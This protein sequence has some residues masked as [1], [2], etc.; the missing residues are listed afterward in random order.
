MVEVS[1]R[2]TVEEVE[3]RPDVGTVRIG[4]RPP[5]RVPRLG[6]GDRRRQ[7]KRHDE[8]EASECAA[9]AALCD[10]CD[11]A[12]HSY[13]MGR[14]RTATRT[15]LGPMETQANWDEQWRSEPF[16]FEAPAKEARTPRWLA[17]ERLVHDRFGSFG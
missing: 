9:P 17:Q 1:R 16:D 11:Q 14:S 6:E 13:R 10:R 3:A 15:S 5:G 7:C 4:V 2:V 12:R 8:R